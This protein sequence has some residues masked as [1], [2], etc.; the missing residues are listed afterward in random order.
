MKIHDHDYG[1]HEGDKK[2]NVGSVVTSWYE[3]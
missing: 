3:C 1:G 2:G